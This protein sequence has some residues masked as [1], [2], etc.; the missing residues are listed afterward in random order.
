MPSSAHP[1]PTHLPSHP[2]AGRRR[3]ATLAALVALLSAVATTHAGELCPCTGDLSGN[4]IIDGAD[5]GAMLAAWGPCEGCAADVSGDGKVDGADLGILLAAWGPC[6][7]D[8]PN[9]DSCA[10][11]TEVPFFTG[12]AN[13]FCTINASTD[14]PAI[15]G[16]CGPPS[17]DAIEQDVW[18]RV[19]APVTATYQIGICADFP[20]R[21]AVYGAN[22]A[23]LCECSQFS[24][25]GPLVAC[26][27]TAAYPACA[28][29]SAM[30]VPAT[31]G[32]C[33]LVRIGGAAGSVGTGNLD[34]NIYVPPCELDSLGTLPASGLEA[35]AEFGISVDISGDVAVAGA[36]F[37]DL[38]F[39]GNGAGSARV[40][41][42]NGVAWNVEQS[43]FSTAPFALQRFGVHVAA[44][45]EWIIV[46]AATVSSDCGA[47]P[48]CDSGSAYVYRYDGATWSHD[49]TLLPGD[50]SPED[51]FGA[52]VDIDGSRAV[53][54]AADDDNVN[55]VRAGAVYVYEFLALFG[56][57]WFETAKLLAPDGENFDRFGS[58][59]AVSGTWVIVGADGADAPGA[60]NSGA[61]YLYRDDPG[62]WT[63]VE[64]FAPAGLSGGANFGRAVAIDGDV[65]VIGAAGN[66]SSPGAAY[67]YENFGPDGWLPV[68]TLTAH[69]GQNGD[70]F[71][72]AVS[73]GGSQIL[74]GAT[75]DDAN[76]GSAYVFIRVS[77][78]WVERAKLVAPDGVAG[79]AFGIGAIDAGRALVGAYLDHVGL[80]AD[81]GTVHIF[82]G[83]GDCTG[84]G[85]TDA[86]DIA[87]GLP[88]ADGDGVPDVCEP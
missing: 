1:R 12:S 62:A 57:V 18:F 26:A 4:G 23:D 32:E 63:H 83:L 69:D 2:H 7:G 15:T 5:L 71:G 66:A 77:G 52:R 88:D 46:G 68:A 74:V 78:G 79:D 58:D 13:P 70:R 72:A 39:G 84:N 31:A 85:V 80:L 22:T 87:A 55:G 33:F 65:V 40:Y 86:C 24:G 19:T 38:L 49:Q 17:I 30:L 11:A 3:G 51:Q 14:G 60:S 64:T 45:G 8:P 10:N 44:S 27:G 43:L 67:V 16:D 61:A 29:G 34:I 41:R 37:D 59:V 28:Q 50:G 35:D 42:W 48:D 82:K 54:G 47:D 36:I 21:A 76:R 25:V 73:V 9:N 56:G 81:V 6:S 20:I 75:G 53:V